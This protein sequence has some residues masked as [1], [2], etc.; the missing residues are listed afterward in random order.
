MPI[1]P[2][3][4]PV[5]SIPN[6][7]DE[8]SQNSV[9]NDMGL[10]FATPGNTATNQLD[11]S[12][13]PSIQP[14]APTG[15]SAPVVLDPP[16]TGAAAPVEVPTDEVKGPSDAL[17][18]AAAAHVL[19]VDPTDDGLVDKKVG[20]TSTKTTTTQPTAEGK[21]ALGEI[22]AAQN[23]V[24]D[25]S[26][27][28]ED[29]VDNQAKIEADFREADAKAI[30]AI[31]T[32]QVAQQQS[33]AA[34]FQATIDQ[35][36]QRVA[37]LANYKPETFWGSKSTSDKI[38]ASL[39]VGLGSF[40][41][42]LTGS[43]QNVGTMLLN[44]QMDEFDKNQQ[45]QYK[46]KMDGIQN[47]KMSLDE[48]QKLATELDK[49]YDTQILASRAQVSSM[50]ARQM[51]MAKTPMVKAQIMKQDAEFQQKT[52]KEKADISEKWATK[53]ENDSK[54]EINERVK[55]A[56]GL[57]MQGKPLNENQQKAVSFYGQMRQAQQ[58]IAQLDEQGIANR[59]HLT[60][61]V[62][63]KQAADSYSKI[64]GIGNAMKGIMESHGHS[65]TDELKTSDPEAYNYL[66]QAQPFINGILRQ[67]SGAAI[68]QEE[69]T[70]AYEQYFPVQGDGPKEIQ[71]KA[72]RRAIATKN[73]YGAT[74]L[75]GAPK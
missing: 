20:E 12:A 27:M 21:A 70:K 45:M 36:D 11:L 1:N 8:I 4:A 41:Q 30:G 50:F 68:S 74:G 2:I 19:G 37:E 51:A 13:D 18:D 16:A 64:P 59:G 73:M 34:K 61:A 6:P 26:K 40:A 38:A 23:E 25:A 39:S 55:A 5:G 17:K 53:I 48:K 75:P 42:S 3:D 22:T 47:M 58:A 44:R 69:F 10:G 46:A 24:K 31:R 43:G 33:N 65:P 60:T 28:A 72:E 56:A 66:T 14:M 52:A 35:I 57:T 67:E 15:I 71:Q 9:Y 29:G 7:I 54:H 62:R 49:N 63:L 32:A